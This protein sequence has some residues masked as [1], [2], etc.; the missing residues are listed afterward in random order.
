MGRCPHDAVMSTTN[1]GLERQVCETCG[2]VSVRFVEDTVRIFPDNP[3]RTGVAATGRRTTCS[4][5]GDQAQFMV[6]DGFACDLHAWS[7]ASNQELTG[8][9][10]WIPIRIDQN[11]VAPG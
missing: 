2:L 1:A 9:D 3:A 11:S 10:L 8:E 6:P 4:A 5:C 7:M